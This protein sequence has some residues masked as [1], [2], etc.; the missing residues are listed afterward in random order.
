MGT[1]KCP[2][3]GQEID[4][5]A[6]KCFFC[7]A[8]LNGESVHQRLEQLQTQDIQA[9]RRIHKPFL[10]KVVVILILAGVIFFYDT[11]VR[12]HTSKVDSSAQSSTVKLKAKVTFPGLQFIILNNDS[13]DW[14]NVK[15]EIT[16]DSMEGRFRLSVPIIISGETYTADATKFLNNEGIRFN[17]DKMEPRKFLILCDTPAGR[18]GSYMADLK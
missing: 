17:P 2:F 11:S 3:C 7:G 5:S 13:F 4:S 9:A 6:K 14:K 8:E 12:K 16:P 15:F 1:E 10:L 18:S